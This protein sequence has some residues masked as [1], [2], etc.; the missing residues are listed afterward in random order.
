MMAI[1]MSPELLVRIVLSSPFP[2]AGGAHAVTKAGVAQEHVMAISPGP[3]AESLQRDAAATLALAVGLD[4][5]RPWPT[6]VLVDQVLGQEP[7]PD[8]LGQLVGVLPGPGGAPRLLLAVCLATVL[9]FL[10]R[11]VLTLLSTQALVT[12]GQRMVYNLGADL[13][14]HLQRQSLLFHS[15][16]PVGDAVGRVTVAGYSP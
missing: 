13:F 10:G 1:R 8:W 9:I 15:R 5:L 11:S 7:L 4:L 2:G 6:K 14:L 16:R 12:V 3:P